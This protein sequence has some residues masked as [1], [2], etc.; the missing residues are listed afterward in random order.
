MSSYKPFRVR[1]NTVALEPE[2]SEIRHGKSLRQYLQRLF[3]ERGI[4]VAAL[5]KRVVSGLVRALFF[6]TPLA[7]PRIFLYNTHTIM[8]NTGGVACTGAMV[9]VLQFVKCP[10][11]A[12]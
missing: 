11:G 9:S 2:N 10:R 7:F 1:G 4:D 5:R 3:K 8:T 6:R 12:I